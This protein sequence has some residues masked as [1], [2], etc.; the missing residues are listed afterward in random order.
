MDPAPPRLPAL[1]ALGINTVSTTSRGVQAEMR[2][3]L[4]PIRVTQ[5][6]NL[7]LAT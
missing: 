5:C 3:V 6:Q 7:F 2:P 4:N 1:D